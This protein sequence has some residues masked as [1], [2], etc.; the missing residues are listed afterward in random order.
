M[1]RKANQR[2]V[3]KPVTV[4]DRDNVTVF[5]LNLPFLVTRVGRVTEQCD[6]FLQRKCSR[7]KKRG[8]EPLWVELCFTKNRE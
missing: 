8:T 4:I 2:L 7:D 5:E 6:A 1:K 3:D